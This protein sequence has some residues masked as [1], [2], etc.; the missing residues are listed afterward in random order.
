MRVLGRLLVVIEALICFGPLLFLLCFGFLFT[1]LWIAGLTLDVPT[2]EPVPAWDFVYPLLLIV[3]GAL[4]TL[5]LLFV[6]LEIASGKRLFST[7]TR[8]WLFL[9]GLAAVLLFNWPW[10]QTLL[11]GEMT[12]DAIWP[13]LIY[14]VLPIAGSIHLLWLAAR[15]LATH[16]RDVQPSGPTSRSGSRLLSW[17]R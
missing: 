12:L 6:L 2:A 16:E 8:T 11:A 10:V 4:G 5:A 9:P 14:F 17:H 13:I 15:R 1:P 7:R 3:L